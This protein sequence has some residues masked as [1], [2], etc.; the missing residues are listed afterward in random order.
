METSACLYKLASNYIHVHI[1]Y[2]KQRYLQR[3]DSSLTFSRMTSYAE[4]RSVA[5][6]SR[7]RS[8]SSNISLTLP[9]ATFL[10]PWVSRWILVIAWSL[11]NAIVVVKVEEVVTRADVDALDLLLNTGREFNRSISHN[12]GRKGVAAREESKS[13]WIP[14]TLGLKNSKSQHTAP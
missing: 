9:L 11:L 13:S 6:N 8:S 14:Y 4:M 7:V 10:N 5:T 3:E 2:L 12:T 1:V